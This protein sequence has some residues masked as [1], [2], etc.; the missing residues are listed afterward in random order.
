MAL[1]NNPLTTLMTTDPG[2]LAYIYKSNLIAGQSALVYIPSPSS[3]YAHFTPNTQLSLHLGQSQVKSLYESKL[4]ALFFFL[5]HLS[6]QLP[7]DLPCWTPRHRLY[8]A[9]ATPKTLVI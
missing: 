2:S 5:P 6:H 1:W 3:L 7:Q 4:R 8:E 9:N